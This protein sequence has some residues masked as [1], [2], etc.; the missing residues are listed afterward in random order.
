MAQEWIVMNCPT[1]GAKMAPSLL[2]PERYQC[3][4]CGNEYLLKNLIGKPESTV[5]KIRPR[6]AA[7]ESVKIERLPDRVRMIH[8]WFSLKYSLRW[9]GMFFW[10]SGTVWHSPPERPGLQFVFPLPMWQLGL[11][12]LIRCSLASSTAQWWN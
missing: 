10:F 9:R 8:R 5:G 7:P 1:C 6:V 4:Y 11:G 2:E 12:S 3:Q